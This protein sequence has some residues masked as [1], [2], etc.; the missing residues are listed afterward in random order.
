MTEKAGHQKKLKQLA[1]TAICGNDI[2]SSCLYVSALTI[3]YAGQYAFISL[4]IV[5]IILFFFRKSDPIRRLICDHGI[6]NVWIAGS[7]TLFASL[8]VSSM[9]S[10]KCNSH[11]YKRA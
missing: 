7:R 6:I 9:V 5:A 3:M 10:Q 11:A 4:I 1:A 8:M 2:T